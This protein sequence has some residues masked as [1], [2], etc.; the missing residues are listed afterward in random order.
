MPHC[1]VTVHLYYPRAVN[2]AMRAE[3]SRDTGARRLQASLP[4]LGVEQLEHG[5]QIRQAPLFF[6]PVCWSVE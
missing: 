2:Q 3:L 6:G 4:G 1:D 5:E